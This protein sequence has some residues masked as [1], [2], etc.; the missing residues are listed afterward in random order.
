MLMEKV[1][2]T[3]S[4]L[5]Y[6]N[7]INYRICEI[8]YLNMKRTNYNTFSSM[9]SNIRDAIKTTNGVRGTLYNV[10]KLTIKDIKVLYGIDDNDAERYFINFLDNNLWEHYQDPVM[11]FITKTPNSFQ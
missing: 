2:K 9:C 7:L 10:A 4:E 8:M 3:K 11:V 5:K 6:E 1:T